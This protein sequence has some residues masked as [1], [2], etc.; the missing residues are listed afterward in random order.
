MFGQNLLLIY[1]D[2]INFPRFAVFG[3]VFKLLNSTKVAG[4]W[5]TVEMP[6]RMVDLRHFDGAVEVI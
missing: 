6:F 2:E 5:K 3:L 1:V 4:I